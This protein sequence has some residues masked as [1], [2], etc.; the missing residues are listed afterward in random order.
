MPAL[1]FEMLEPDL[2]RIARW[3]GAGLTAYDA[4]YVALAEEAGV[5]LVTDDAGILDVAP[6]LATAPAGGG[7]TPPRA[8]RGLRPAAG[9]AAPAGSSVG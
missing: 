3:A 2:A 8:A 6:D 5:Q 7:V 1:G 9:R 4:T